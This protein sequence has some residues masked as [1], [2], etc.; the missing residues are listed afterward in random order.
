M[1]IHPNVH[2]LLVFFLAYLLNHKIYRKKKQ[3]EQKLGVTQWSGVGWDDCHVQ[4]A[5]GHGSSLI[6]VVGV[7]LFLIFISFFFFF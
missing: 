6:I 2:G 1:K 3:K 4:L 7:L 5:Q